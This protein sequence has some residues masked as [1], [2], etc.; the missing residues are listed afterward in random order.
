MGNLLTEAL[1]FFVILIAETKDK[2]EKTIGY[3]SKEKDIK[4]SDIVIADE[5][6]KPSKNIF[7]YNEY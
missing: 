6:Q 7:Y 1:S 3:L 4:Y 5:K 2:F